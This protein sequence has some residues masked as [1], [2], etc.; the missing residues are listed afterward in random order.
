M[1]RN[2]L[3]NW[4]QSFLFDHDYLIVLYDSS[5]SIVQNI[6]KPKIYRVPKISTSIAHRD[7][8]V[9]LTLSL[10]MISIYLIHCSG[11]WTDVI[12]CMPYHGRSIK[13]TTTFMG[14]QLVHMDGVRHVITFR[15]RPHRAGH[16]RSAGNPIFFFFFLPRTTTCCNLN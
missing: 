12:V 8:S 9:G 1:C 13:W 2:I 15:E 14:V 4:R 7:T 5:Y 3:H 11:L 6:L 10:I 16:Q